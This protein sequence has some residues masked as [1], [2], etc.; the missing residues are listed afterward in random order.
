MDF[1][2]HVGRPWLCGQLCSFEQKTNKL[3]VNATKVGLKLNAQ[4]YKTMKSNSKKQQSNK[5]KKK[6]KSAHI[7]WLLTHSRQ[8]IALF[9]NGILNTVTF[10]SFYSNF[11]K[12]TQSLFK[13]LASVVRF[14]FKLLTA[15]NPTFRSCIVLS[16]EVFVS[17]ESWI[18]ERAN[19]FNDRLCMS[20]LGSHST[21]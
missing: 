8:K 6:I 18:F 13:F 4:N 12:T 5:N 15:T 21:N 19:E 2:L 9:E 11:I 7:T 14:L 3:E 16:Q 1:H 10:S 17:E 20:Q